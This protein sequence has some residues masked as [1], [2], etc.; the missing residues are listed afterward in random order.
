MENV[1]LVKGW[2]NE[3]CSWQN[4]IYSVTPKPG[5]QTFLNIENLWVYYS[6]LIVF[7]GKVLFPTIHGKI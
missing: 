7:P 4:I 5:K 6:N 1:W 2:E 3:E